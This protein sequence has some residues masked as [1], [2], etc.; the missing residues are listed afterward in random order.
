MVM[1]G[2][3]LAA[4]ADYFVSPAGNDQNDGLSAAAPWRTIGRA[5]S[6]GLLPGDTLSF[7]GGQTFA[8][9]IQLYQCGVDT[10]LV[11]VRSYGAG[12]A[13]IVAAKGS[14]GIDAYNCEAVTVRDLVVTSA[15]GP[16][17]GAA[18]VSFYVDQVNT[19]YRHITIDNVDVSGFA[20][21]LLI[22]GNRGTSGYDGLRVTRV[23]AH[24]NQLAGINVWGAEMFA[25][26][27]LY[28]GDSQAY[29]NP[30]DPALGGNSGNG[31]VIGSVDG[32]LIER[33]VAHDNGAQCF[34][35]ECAAGIWA[36]DSN[37]VTIQHNESYDNRTGGGVD[38][39]GFD[40]DLGVT[41][42]VMQYNYSHG[43]E[44]AGYLILQA[45]RG[46]S[47]NT[48]RYNISVNDGVRAGYGAIRVF[49]S[50]QNLQIYGNTLIVANGAPGL[51]MTDGA[52]AGVRLLNNLIV[53][54]SGSPFMTGAAPD[55]VEG[56]RFY[57]GVSG[58]DPLLN[59]SAFSGTLG[60]ARLLETLAAFRLN[61]A[62]PIAAAGV[63][64]R[65]RGIDPGAR[66]FF[67]SALAAVT[68]FS[69]GAHQVSGGGSTV[70]APRPPANVKIIRG[71]DD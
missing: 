32:G 53:A 71:A 23:S 24:H 38:G 28:I 59:D 52:P 56:N 67:G 62:S 5:N 7:E 30:G 49:G 66:D 70:P 34:A 43:N 57:N 25:H 29:N 10:Q 15:G 27:D 9:T 21:G 51:R 22:G 37:R 1:C 64:L 19:R 14:R 68:Q 41:N 50:V 45:S 2:A 40:L 35:G 42:S 63:D 20:T 36:Y 47:G 33:S 44:G 17:G 11:T 6:R 31:I 18:G 4:A 12:R 48:V 54:R 65:A 16:S 26:K 55:L 58:A 3:R 8:G 39:D 46:N 69:I 13:T 60:D 61:P